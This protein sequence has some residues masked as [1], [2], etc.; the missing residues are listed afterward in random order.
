MEAEQTIPAVK[1]GGRHATIWVYDTPDTHHPYEDAYSNGDDMKAF[2]TAVNEALLRCDRWD[3]EVFEIEIVIR[4]ETGHRD[5]DHYT[6]ERWESLHP[7]SAE[8]ID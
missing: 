7:F 4:W 6:R 3:R 8:A 1:I 5:R 2:A